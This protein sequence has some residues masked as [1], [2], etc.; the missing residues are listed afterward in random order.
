EA[1]AFRRAAL[2]DT[3]DDA[4]TAFI[5]T[6]ASVLAAAKYFLSSGAADK[7]TVASE[8]AAA[9]SPDA[10]E[11]IR[12]EVE[13]VGGNA[14]ALAS[15][16]SAIEETRT[17]V[18][19]AVKD[20]ICIVGW[21]G[22]GTTDIGVNPFHGEYINVGTHAAVADT[23]LSRSFIRVTGPWISV[24]L[25][26][27]LAPLIILGIGRFKP[28][29]RSGMG[30][31]SVLLILAGSFALFA[32]SGIFVG[33][34]GPALAM[35]IAVVVREALDFMGAEREKRFL[36]KAFGTYLSGA[37]VEEIISDPS[38]LK[39]GGSK[40]EMTA[41]FTDVRGFSTIS[42]QLDPEALVAL[43]NRYLSG[44][45]DI[46]L[47]EKGTIDKYEGDAIISFFGAPLDL[48]DHALRA[49]R[50]AIL[51]KRKETALNELF[52]AQGLAPSPLATRIGINSGDMVVGNMGT[53]RK[54]N[55]TIMGNA[56]NLA[57]RLE[58]VNKQYGSW[59]L[60]SDATVRATGSEL[61]VRRMDRV[62]V[63]GIQEPVRLYEVLDLA[64][65]ATPLMAQV[66]E[67]FHVA[68]D[69]FEEKDWGEATERFKAVLYL[70]PEDGPAGKYLERCKK[71]GKTP[72]AKNWDGVFNLTEK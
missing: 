17:I 25:S 39:L 37:V 4:F 44:M 29:V 53:E 31:F 56:V 68:M 27:L 67:L 71:F 22:T 72:P 38:R 36:R 30:F 58:G 51:M 70:S 64:S 57:A 18:S 6:R 20:K 10:A 8:L 3:D 66:V 60:A 16:V 11:E 62:R 34:L 69:A 21:V 14:A 1:G 55:Y 49:C 46:V 19:G 35:T 63:V 43:L 50:S 23:I 33:P 5:A 48:P 15:I 9:S 42:E 26:F 32:A 40:R 45:S 47:D 13:R 24:L 41:L 54:M 61:L 7:L 2:D 59:I 65:D 28:G 12:T 52:L